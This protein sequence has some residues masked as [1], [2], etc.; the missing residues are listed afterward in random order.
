MKVIR[1]AL[2]IWFSLFFLI[3]CSNIEKHDEK[4]ENSI[5]EDWI[6]QQLIFE[7]DQKNIKIMKDY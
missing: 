3:S 4:N 6:Q 7:E 1:K 2:L 5:D